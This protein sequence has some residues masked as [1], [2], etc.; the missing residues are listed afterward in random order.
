MRGSPLNTRPDR[1]D[2]TGDP[3]V[4]VKARSFLQFSQWM[5][6]RLAELVERWAHTAAPNAMRP[7]RRLPA[8]PKPKAK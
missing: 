7:R 4:Q 3:L 8:K 6:G 5:D 2:A 1:W